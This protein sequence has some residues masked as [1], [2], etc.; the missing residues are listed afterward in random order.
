MALL[1]W[2]EFRCEVAVFLLRVV[3]PVLVKNNECLLVLALAGV[4]LLVLVGRRVTVCKMDNVRGEVRRPRRLAQ[5]ALFQ[6]HVVEQRARRTRPLPHRAH[7]HSLTQTRDTFLFKQLCTTHESVLI[8][9]RQTRK[10]KK[11][12]LPKHQTTNPRSFLVLVCLLLLVGEEQKNKKG[13]AKGGE[14]EPRLQ[15][16]RAMAG[17]LFKLQFILLF[18]KLL[19]LLQLLLFLLLFLLQ[20]LLFSPPI[21]PRFCSALFRRQG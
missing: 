20:L 17:G 6:P 4:F 10:L 16:I 14:K 21:H 1:F 11:S 7:R 18:L 15:R 9:T 19:K 8:K 12:V 5:G 3:I 2:T 13:R